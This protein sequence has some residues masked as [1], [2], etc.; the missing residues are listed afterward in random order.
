MCWVPSTPSSSIRPP[1]S[2]VRPATTAG[3]RGQ[4]VGIGAT[5]VPHRPTPPSP[6]T[7][8]DHPVL[9]AV[10]LRDRRHR[11]GKPVPTTTKRTEIAMRKIIV[12]AAGAAVAVAGLVGLAGPA[13]ASPTAAE[14]GTT[15]TITQHTT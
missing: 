10:A 12:A 11:H 6:A 4:R 14:T 9:W 8:A 7:S 2:R 5:P 3:R 1:H 13:I 15:A